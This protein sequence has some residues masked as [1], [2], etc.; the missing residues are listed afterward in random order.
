MKRP[1]SHITFLCMLFA[2]VSVASSFLPSLAQAAV[3][4][5]SSAKLV[6]EAS[7]QFH[8]AYRS[9]PTEGKHRQEQLNAV[10]AAWHAAPQSEANN[11]RLNTW[12]RAAIRVSMPGSRKPLPP[13]PMFTANAEREGRLVIE[14]TPVE[15]KAPEPTPAIDSP[16]ST[17]DAHV[18]PF[19]DDPVVGQKS[20]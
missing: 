8:L 2:F 15:V 20:K 11:E 1:M 17:D 4:S 14:P 9:Y 5:E 3:T 7:I 18:N 13:S 6:S 12:L 10:V 16:T 19:R